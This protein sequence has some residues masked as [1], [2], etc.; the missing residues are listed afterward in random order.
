MDA[1]TKEK[2]PLFELGQVV[3]TR[4]AITALEEADQSPE[5]FL[6]RHVT[7][8]WSNL[9]DE[10]QKENEFSVEHGFRI[11]SSYL[12]NQNVKIWVITEADRSVTTLLRPHEY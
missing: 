4:G 5:E 11:F 6:I 10:D 2:Q 8:D 1:T 3:A 7:G 9:P 12:T